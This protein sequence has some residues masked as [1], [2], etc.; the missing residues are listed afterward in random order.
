MQNI[1]YQYY[2]DVYRTVNNH[3]NTINSH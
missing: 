1:L 2:S 3:C